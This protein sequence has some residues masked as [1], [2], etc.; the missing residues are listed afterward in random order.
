MTASSN[1]EVSPDRESAVEGLQRLRARRQRLGGWPKSFQLNEGESVLL[2]GAASHQRRLRRA[3]G[4]L[5]LTEKRLLFAPFFM[6]FWESALDWNLGD[7]E[8]L[9]EPAQSLRTRNILLLRMDVWLLTAWHLRL[10]G[11][12]HCFYTRRDDGWLPALAAATGLTPVLR[13]A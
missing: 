9:R 3:R 7:I 11:K 1:D 5:Y 8:E 13:D 2:S 4:T 10:A 12:D 6:N